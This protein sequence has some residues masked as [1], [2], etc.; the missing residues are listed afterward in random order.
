MDDNFLPREKLLNYGINSLEDFEVLSI[1]LRSGTKD[2]NVFDLSK[3]IINEMISIENI[4]D[5]TIN[6][7]MHYK[8]IGLSKASTILC[9]F[10]L[11]KRVNKRRNTR[12]EIK[13]PKDIYNA[14]KDEYLG[15]NY[16]MYTVLF[17]D[18]SSKLISKFNQKGFSDKFIEIDSNDIIRRALILKAYAI[19]LVH[20]HPSGDTTPSDSDLIFTNNLIRKLEEFNLV[21]L[22]HIILYENTYY[23]IRYEIKGKIKITS[24]SG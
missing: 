20:N 17:L 19:C 21:M 22:D 13:S 10:E 24:K 8:G 23:S 16:E 7:L 15:L 14:V 18:T 6:D 2:E 1:L 12:L 11:Y 3:R 4:M 9:A 5:L